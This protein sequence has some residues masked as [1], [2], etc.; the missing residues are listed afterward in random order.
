MSAAAHICSAG[1]RWC[2]SSPV[3]D[4]R[5]AVPRHRYTGRL[6]LCLEPLKDQ[7]RT[8]RRAQ[9]ALR[10]QARFLPLSGLPSRPPPNR[11]ENRMN[12]NKVKTQGIYFLPLGPMLLAMILSMK[13]TTPSTITCQRPGTSSR[14]I[15]PIMKTYRSPRTTNIHNALLVKLIC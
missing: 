9:P 12:M 7:C 13:P 10:K 3:P 5:S 11:L 1:Y 8:K 2:A 15:P 14:F 4:S 6:P